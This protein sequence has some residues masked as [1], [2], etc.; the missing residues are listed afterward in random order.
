MKT[1]SD[2]ILYGNS[3]VVS[4]VTVCLNSEPYME[5]TIQSVLNQTYPYVEY[6]IVDGGSNDGTISTIKKY[7]DRIT[8]WISEPDEGIYDAMNKG[9]SLCKGD[10][11]YCLNSG[12]Y[13]YNKNILRKVAEQF[14]DSSVMGVYGNVE[15][16]DEMGNNR[17]R[18]S[19]VTYNT[20]LYK[21]VCHQALFV[22]KTLFDEFG[23]F[24]TSYK[25]SSDH[26][27]VIKCIKKYR[28][29]FVYLNETIAVYMSGGM[30][31]M[32]M[33]K[34]KLEDLKILSSNYDPVRFLLGAAVCLA[35]IVKY[36]LPGISKL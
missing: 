12:D 35:V 24:S 18:G 16:R 4:I 3:P 14:F 33:K 22:R 29:S 7:E 15:V 19:E 36:K 5:K 23:K 34:T 2:S 8:K 27:F 11:I 10:I 9:I 21:R 26:E 13:L 30:S 28:H 31:C 32:Q 25:L 6:I 20:L 17:I 1:E